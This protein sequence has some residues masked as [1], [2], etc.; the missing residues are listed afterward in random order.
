MLSYNAVDGINLKKL[1]PYF[2]KQYFI[3]LNYIGQHK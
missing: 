2:I 1:N 3:K